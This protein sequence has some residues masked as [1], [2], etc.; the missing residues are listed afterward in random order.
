M[1]AGVPWLS[2]TDGRKCFICKNGA[3]DGD[4]FFFD[5]M[6]FRENSTILWSNLKTTLSDAHPLERNFMFGF[7]VNL[8]REHKTKFLLGGLSLPFDSKTTTIV[9]RY[10]STAV[11][12]IYKICSNKLC[13]LES[14]WLKVK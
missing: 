11:G 1:N 12:K 14:P 13:D 2:D 9:K 4:H 10:I 6:S 3:E 8:D 5:C 7:L